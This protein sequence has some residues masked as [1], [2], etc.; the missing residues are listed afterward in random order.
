MSFLAACCLVLLL[1]GNP[2]TA[3]VSLCLI[4]RDEEHNLPACLGPVAD[5]V[6]EIVV[7]DTGSQ[8]QTRQVAGRFGARVIDFPWIDSFAAARNES[9]RHATQPW[10]FW[11]DAD[12]RL[13]QANRQQLAALFAS[14]ADDN[15]AYLM[16]SRSLSAG[17]GAGLTVHHARLF[18]NHPAI[19]W[20]YRV[21]EQILPAILRQGGVLH[22][23]EIAIIHAGYQDTALR[24]RK[25]ERNLRLLRMD[26]ADR[27]DDPIVLFHLGW[28]LYALGRSEEALPILSRSLQRTSPSAPPVRKLYALLARTQRRLGHKDEALAL[29]AQGLQRFPD[30]PELLFLEGLV[31]AQSGDL[32]GAE[33]CL[34]RLLEQRPEPY[35]AAGVDP[36]WN[37]VKAR[38]NLGVV[39]RDQGRSAEALAAFQAVVAEQPAHS[40]AWIALADLWLSLGKT[41]EVE[42]ALQ[43]LEADP[44]RAVEAA[45]LRSRLHCHRQE[46]PGAREVLQEAL[47]R[48]PDVLAL[49][50]ALGDTL[51]R[52]NRD[53]P[54]IEQALRAVL[55]LDPGNQR[56][57]DNLA[58]IQRRQAP[59]AGFSTGK[60]VVVSSA[61]PVV[62]SPSPAALPPPPR[63]A[64]EAEERFHQAEKAFNEGRHDEAALLYRQLLAAKVTPGVML[65]RL[66]MISNARRDHVAAWDLHQQAV[67]LDP[68]LPSR[69]TPPS[70][71][72]HQT[73]LRAQHA[74][75]DVPHCP[76]CGSGEQRPLA[77]VSLLL[78]QIYHPAFHPVRRWVGCAECGHAFANP[79][80]AAA[81]LDEAHRG[82]LPQRITWDYQKM[83]VAGETVEA[84]WQHRPGG[85]FLD[86]GVAEGSLAGVAQDFGY[87]V[88]GL[89]RHAGYAEAVRHLGVE[90]VR[91]DV[92]EHDFGER[93]F[94]VIA[95]GNVVAQCP[96]P[97]RVMSRVVSLLRPGGLVWLS[98]PDRAGVWARAQGE[99]DG[100]WLEGEHLHYFSRRSLTALLNEQRLVPDAFR[101]SKSSRGSIELTCRLA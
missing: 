9:I 61:S 98:T 15:A 8:D 87:R 82:P 38:Y 2:M 29:C 28:T 12:D 92:V 71:A 57:R 94:D 77:V 24:H 35:M 78:G 65:F 48:C 55:E 45:L 90:F 64:R 33:S 20:E 43:R 25:E 21:H 16:R 23:T 3:P 10:I 76:V 42:Q 40:D 44:Q 83:L 75:E 80:P 91:A 14:L 5:L 85:D 13:D 72:H 6:T 26:E 50:L 81:A 52:E 37:G 69:I 31:R 17:G 63:N 34:V 100:T 86:V 96:D 56:A 95:L 47:A 79:R 46:F 88:C 101:L 11:L 89:D 93:H 4:A 30:D 74:T 19:R 7:V 27:P 73:R 39:Y 68:Q 54:A 32:G 84:L 1:A 60:P 41:N 97:R 53:Q 62:S 22:H 66:G 59:P 36:E 51:L 18:R 99:K 58:A 67:A 70:L 49:R